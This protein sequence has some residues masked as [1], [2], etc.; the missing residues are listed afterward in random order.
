MIKNDMY[1][2]RDCSRPGALNMLSIKEF[3]FEK[4]HSK[5]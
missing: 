5:I 4:I 2:S 1:N 3:S